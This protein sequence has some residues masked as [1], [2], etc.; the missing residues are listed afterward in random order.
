MTSVTTIS[1]SATLRSLGLQP[2]D[3]LFVDEMHDDQVTMSLARR[4]S[5]HAGALTMDQFL[6]KWMG[7][8]PL[9]SAEDDPRLADIIAKHVK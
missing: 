1:A 2:G 9:P 8:F 7:K 4:S 6:D 5:D 3:M